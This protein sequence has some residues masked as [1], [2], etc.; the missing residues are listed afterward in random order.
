MIFSN[1]SPTYFNLTP[2]EGG[3]SSDSGLSTARDRS[4]SSSPG[5]SSHRGALGWVLM[6]RRTAGERE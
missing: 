6:R 3:S 5:C 1:T 2:I 4:R